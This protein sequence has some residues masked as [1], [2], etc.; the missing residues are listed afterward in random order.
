MRDDEEIIGA[1]ERELTEDDGDDGGEVTAGRAG[2]RGFLI[3]A[4]ALVLGCVLLVV[5]ILANRPLANTIAHAQH[6]LRTAQAAAEGIQRETGSFS[7]ASAGDL[8]AA[9]PGLTFREGD[10]PSTGLNDVSVHASSD[11]WAAAVRAR[12][13][14]CFYLKLEVDADA[15]Y[16]TG[17]VCSGTAAL[18]ADESRW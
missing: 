5:Q 9:E 8:R 1:Y 4:G 16:G 15:T 11:V 3:V 12:P 2:G 13:G 6:T 18:A 7:D 17:E 10:Q 14:A